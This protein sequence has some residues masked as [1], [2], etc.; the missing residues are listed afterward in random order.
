MV[1]GIEQTAG[2]AQGVTLRNS[3]V[4]DIQDGKLRSTTHKKL[5]ALWSI[6]ITPD[7][8]QTWVDYVSTKLT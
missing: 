5:L 2:P 8:D 7:A 1:I 6:S 3:V 4:A